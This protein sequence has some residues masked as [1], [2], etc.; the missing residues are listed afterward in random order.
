MSTLVAVIASVGIIVGLF[1]AWV[2]VT[3][4]IECRRI[5]KQM[6]LSFWEVFGTQ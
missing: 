4:I 5:A 6:G 2:L 1:G 3:D